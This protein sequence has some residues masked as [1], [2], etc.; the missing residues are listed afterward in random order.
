MGKVTGLSIQWLLQNPGHVVHAVRVLFLFLWGL[1]WQLLL[2][3]P[4]WVAAY[5]AVVRWQLL[6]T[7]DKMAKSPVG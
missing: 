4:V 5:V 1:L 6:R 2:I 7:R 3:Y